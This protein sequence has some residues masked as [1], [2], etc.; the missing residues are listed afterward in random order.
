M[1]INNT[2]TTT[3]VPQF[4]GFMRFN[5][6]PVRPVLGAEITPPIFGVPTVTTLSTPKE[7]GPNFI[8]VRYQ[9][10]SDNG[11]MPTEF[12]LCYSTNPNVT[13]NDSKKISS[14]LGLGAYVYSLTNLQEGTT[15][16][17][18]AY[19]INEYGVGYGEEIAVTTSTRLFEN[20]YEYVDL[21]LSVKWATMNVGATSPEGYG[22]YFAWGETEPK[23]IYEWSTYKWCE[24]T[25]NSQ[26]KYN[27]H[28][29]YGRVDNKTTLELSDDVAHANW[30]GSWRMP[31]DAEMT[32]LRNNCTW[33]W[34]IQNGVNGYK[35][36]SKN[37]GNSIFLPAAGYRNDNSV[38]SVG[39]HG[40]YLSSSLNTDSPDRARLLLINPSGVY[41]DYGYR[42]CGMSIRPICIIQ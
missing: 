33:T 12:G 34:F 37:N 25:Y 9:I 31:T 13:I 15:Y 29:S 40:Y 14:H 16:Y 26:I 41:R 18:R 35:V 7:I 17:I 23:E 3:N 4:F 8:T 20:G 30:G 38:Y 27:N 5:G 28:S 32:E 42:R 6:D 22:D 1:A 2:D 10:N 24:G 11:S 36:T 39:S 21:G 19:A